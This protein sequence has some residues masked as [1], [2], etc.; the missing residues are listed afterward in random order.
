ML[1]NPSLASQ[2]EI[3]PSWKERRE[4]VP[5]KE[6][7][8]FPLVQ[9]ARAVESARSAP[10]S[11]FR[12]PELCRWVSSLPEGF[13]LIVEYSAVINPVLNAHKANAAQSR[14]R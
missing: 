13:F 11:S 8:G 4:R 10:T 14:R 9:L 7:L 2:R 6:P 12:G 1:L 5:S 3:F